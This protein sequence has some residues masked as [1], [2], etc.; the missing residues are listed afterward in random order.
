MRHALVLLSILLCT[1]TAATAQVR[2]AIGVPSVTIGI[3]LPAYPEFVRVPRYPVYYAPRLDSN[4]FFYDGLYWVYQGDN[5]YASSWYNGPWGRVAPE[6]VPVYVLRVPVRYYRDRPTY[7]SG[8]RDDAPPRWGEYWGSEWEQ[9]R[10][11]WDSWNRNS[12]PAP[13]P[14]PVYQRRYSGDRYPTVDQQLTLHVQSYRYQPRDA[15]ARQYYKDQAAQAA[16]AAPRQKAQKTQSAKEF[17]PGQVKKE[18]GR[19]SA[20]EFAPGQVKKEQGR[21]SARELAPGQQGKEQRAPERGS[22]S[23][24]DDKEHGRG[25]DE[26]RGGK[27]DK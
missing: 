9:R 12:A 1:V 14:L 17:A 5:W 22:R 23:K 11:G 13:A 21:Q 25:N 6:G 8:W 27:R 20:K 16:S 2:I 15:V 4:V 18:Q 24:G 10:S 19:Q 7:F 26:G 3:S